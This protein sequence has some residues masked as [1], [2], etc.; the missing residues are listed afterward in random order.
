M[1]AMQNKVK[2]LLSDYII[3]LCKQYLQPYKTQGFHGILEFNMPNLE[4]FCIYLDETIQYE[5]A[6]PL[7]SHIPIPNVKLPDT[8]DE[9]CSNMK[10]RV[11]TTSQSAVQIPSL[12][13]KK[14]EE[15]SGFVTGSLKTNQ[16]I[17]CH[18]TF[19]KGCEL[20]NHTAI[21][22]KQGT[23]QCNI[24]K[25]MFQNRYNLKIHMRIHTSEKPYKCSRCYKTFNSN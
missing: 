22:T 16:G 7:Q 3:Q 25:K 21:C 20:L 23:F 15:L 11:E 14:Q 5:I 6:V 10:S 13:E 8:G 24:C 12:N 19:A 4:K 9:E 17:T 2:H 1:E 18:D